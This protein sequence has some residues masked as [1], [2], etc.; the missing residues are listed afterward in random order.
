ML[1]KTYDLSCTDLISAGLTLPIAMVVSTCAKCQTTEKVTLG[2]NAL[3]A[4]LAVAQPRD[5]VSLAQACR[6]MYQ[7]TK[8]ELNLALFHDQAGLRAA[9]TSCVLHLCYL[10]SRL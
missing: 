1:D 10:T 2:P 6:D 3:A 8:A 9:V 4:V 7:A 5:T